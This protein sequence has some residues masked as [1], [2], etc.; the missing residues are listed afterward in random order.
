MKKY[1]ITG[2][3]NPYHA[4][5]HFDA[6]NNQPLEYDLATPVKWVVDDCFGFGYDLEEARNI[7]DSYADRMSD[8]TSYEDDAWIA[9]MVAEATEYDVELDVSWY[10]GAGWYCNETLVYQHGDD[11]LYD[12]VMLYCIEEVGECEGYDQN[13]RKQ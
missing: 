12:D 3:C 6:S 11:T 8:D 9:Q 2:R 10:K 5:F 13:W 4:Q 1:I 7:L